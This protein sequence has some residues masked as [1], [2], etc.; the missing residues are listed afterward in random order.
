MADRAGRRTVER[1]IEASRRGAPS[2]SDAQVIAVARLAK[3]LE[4]SLGGPQDV[5]WAI[6]RELPGE[7]AVVALQ[8]RPETVW[9]RKGQDG[10]TGAAAEAKTYAIGVEG[11]IGT[12]LSPLRIKPTK[13]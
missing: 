2:L 8:S 12:L 10:K 13:Q 9:S 1:A 5:E 3:A 6:D 11:V 7:D 4:K